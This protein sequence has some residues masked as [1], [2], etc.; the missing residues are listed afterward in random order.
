MSIQ[1]TNKLKKTKGSMIV[2]L[3]IRLAS[4]LDSC[5]NNDHSKNSLF[6]LMTNLLSNVS[7]FS[8]N[9]PKYPKILDWFCFVCGEK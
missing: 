6:L 9:T 4:R 3:Y 1:K 2:E 7:Q 8:K 5:S